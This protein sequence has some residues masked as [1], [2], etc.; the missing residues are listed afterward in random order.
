MYL[1]QQPSSLLRRSPLQTR[2]CE[3][4][5][6]GCCE[7]CNHSANSQGR[8]SS[9][10]TQRQSL[11]RLSPL[12]R[13]Q[14]LIWGR[15]LIHKDEVGWTSIAFLLYVTLEAKCVVWSGECTSFS[16]VILPLRFD[17]PGHKRRRELLWSNKYSSAV[18]LKP[19]AISRN[20]IRLTIV[21]VY[22]HG[23]WYP[24]G[25]DNTAYTIQGIGR[26]MTCTR[27]LLYALCLVLTVWHAI[28]V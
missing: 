11:P 12:G 5:G 28:D 23:L 14:W 21:T 26:K 1:I 24:G 27:P 19:T 18:D 8:T 10:R 3:Y 20:T 17:F 6:R 2:E 22:R 16:T 15:R 25:Y 7:G 4:F 13:R 9:Y